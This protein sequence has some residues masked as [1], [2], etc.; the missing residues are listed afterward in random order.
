M[1]ASD[2]IPPAVFAGRPKSCARAAFARVTARQVRLICDADHNRQRGGKTA[3]DAQSRAHATR[4]RIREAPMTLAWRALGLAAVLFAAVLPARAEIYRWTDAEGRVHFTE[5]IDQVPPEHRAAA[6]ER[7]AANAPD[8]VH[9]YSGSSSNGPASTAPGRAV[10]RGEIEVPFTRIGSLMRVEGTV[11]D[12]VKVPF[13]VDTGASGVSIPNTYAAKLGVRLRSDTPR[14]AV[15]T[16]NGV[17]AR[18]VIALESIDVEGAR[19]ENLS[20]TLDPGLEF[21]LLGGSFFNNYVYRVDA[22][23]SVMTLVPN[24]Q[25]RGGLGERQWRERFESYTDPLRRLEDYLRD[26]PYLH[27]QERTKLAAR[28]RELRAGLRDLERDADE[29]GVPQMWREGNEP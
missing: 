26:H 14:V 15:T 8:R 4:K 13:L 11:N 20:A 12:H 6:R 3:S 23:R 21:G 24:D 5:R 1:L 22:A 7:A 19:V 10:R 2:A 27:E 17:V 28:E 29:A 18:P 9:T 16:A 25:M